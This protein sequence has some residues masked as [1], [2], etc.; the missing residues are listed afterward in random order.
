[1]KG[2]FSLCTLPTFIGHDH[3][4]I[5][6]LICNCLYLY[7]FAWAFSEALEGWSV[8]TKEGKNAEKAPSDNDCCI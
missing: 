8:L 2:K 4:A 1:M 6:Q 3:L 5:L 7:I